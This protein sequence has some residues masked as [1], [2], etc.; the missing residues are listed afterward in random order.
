MPVN[1][2]NLPGLAVVDFREPATEYH[3]RAK[4][5]VSHFRSRL[6]HLTG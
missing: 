2:L 4:P 3:V 6:V 5:K 1:I